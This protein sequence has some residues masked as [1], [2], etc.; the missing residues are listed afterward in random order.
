M[1]DEGADSRTASSSGS[2]CPKGFNYDVF[3]SFRGPDTRD[4]FADRLHESLTYSGF[5]GF[6]DDK[7][8]RQDEEIGWKILQ[9]I[10]DS[11]ICIPIFSTRYASSRWCLRELAHMMECAYSDSSGGPTGHEMLPIFYNVEPSDLKLETKLYG[12]ALRKHEK[13]QGRHVVKPWKEA[14]REVAKIKGW[15]V[16]GQRLGK[17]IQDIKQEFSSRMITRERN[18]HDDLVGL[19]DRVEDL[20]KLLDPTCADIRVVVIYSMGRIGKTTLAN[21]VYNELSPLF[22]G[23]CFLRDVQESSSQFDGI[24]KLQ[25][26]LLW[27]LFNL[28]RPKTFDI[29]EGVNMIKHRLPNKRVLIVLDDVDDGDQLMQLAAKPDWFCPR[30]RIIITT[31]DTSV[32]PTTKVE[33]LEESVLTQP[34]KISPY[35]MKELHY[36]HALQHFSKHAFSTDSHLRDFEDLSR[37]V[38]ATTR[39][40]PLAL[41]GTDNVVALALLGSRHN[42]NH[43]DFV[44]LSKIRFLELDGGNFTGDFENMFPKLRWLCWRHCPSKL[45]ANNFL[46]KSLVILKLSSNI[47]IDEWSR[48]VQIMMGS[49][50]KVLNLKGSKFL[51]RTPDFIGCLNLERLIIRDCENLNEIDGSIRNLEQIKCLKIKWCPH[52]KDLPE[53]IGCLSSLRELILIQCQYVRNLPPW[54]GNLKVLSRLVMEG[55]GLDRLPQ[56]ISELVDL[57]Y[58]S[59]MNC[60][61]LEEL[62]F[63][64]GMLKSLAELDLSG[65]SIVAVK[66]NTCAIRFKL[67]KNIGRFTSYMSAQRPESYADIMS[68]GELGSSLRLSEYSIDL[69]MKCEIIQTEYEVNLHYLPSCIRQISVPT[70]FHAPKTRLASP[71]IV[72]EDDPLGMTIILSPDSFGEVENLIPSL[73]SM[74]DRMRATSFYFVG[75]LKVR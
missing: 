37:K 18:G 2:D 35:E 47:I 42:F 17:V 41:E 73:A 3:L 20:K 55:L 12:D 29:D 34:I 72:H 50:L 61:G 58:L 36:D 32:I 19:T 68:K 62:P 67:E 66:I 65:T 57:K 4:G 14:L 6:M 59:L 74:L 8:I 38:V 23:R 13:E 33:G 7:E 52:L 9:A 48:W 10:E 56:E 75:N 30:S 24:V 43:E 64:I 22:Q 5:R 54:V 11:K 45:Q 63:T 26:K 69:L 25:K 1:K 40:L 39:G 60:T 27:D 71:E 28:T 53:E 31:R 51:T 44:D 70:I 46:L 16:K 49:Q 15:K 21:V